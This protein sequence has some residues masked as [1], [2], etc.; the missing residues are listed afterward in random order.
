MACAQ[1]EGKDLNSY[2]ELLQIQLLF[3]IVIL[4]VFKVPARNLTMNIVQQIYM[5]SHE[6][7]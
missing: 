1:L 7:N 2:V 6:G 4:T 5:V 3:S